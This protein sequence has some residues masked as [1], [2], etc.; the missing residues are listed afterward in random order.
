MGGS[1]KVDKWLT[2]GLIAGLVMLEDDMVFWGD[3]P[4]GSNYI[5]CAR[6]Y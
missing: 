6:H 5:V 2:G 4:V 1:G 3:R